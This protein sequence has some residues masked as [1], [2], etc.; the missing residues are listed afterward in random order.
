V[1]S[2]CI[3]QGF[4]LRGKKL[5]NAPFRP[6]VLDDSLIHIQV[7]ETYLWEVFVHRHIST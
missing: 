1:S 6:E 2:K 5:L 4:T 3:W 7:C